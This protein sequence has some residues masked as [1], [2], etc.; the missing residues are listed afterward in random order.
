MMAAAER[1]WERLRDELEKLI[2]IGFK[3]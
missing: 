1:T 2:Y 3:N